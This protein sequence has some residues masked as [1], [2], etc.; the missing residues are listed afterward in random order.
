MEVSKSAGLYL[1]D[2]D[3]DVPLETSPIQGANEGKERFQSAYTPS[4]PPPSK[5]QDIYAYTD[6]EAATSANYEE[7]LSSA[8]R[9]EL[10]AQRSQDG[11]RYLTNSIERIARSQPLED[12]ADAAYDN[13]DEGA[14]DD[15]GGREPAT[16]GVTSST[17]EGGD[18]NE[19]FQQWM[20]SSDSLQKYILL[21]QHARDF[22]H[23]ASTFGTLADAYS[24]SLGM[25]LTHSTFCHHRGHQGRIIIFERDLPVHKKSIKPQTGLGY[26]WAHTPPLVLPLGELTSLFPLPCLVVRLWP[27]GRRREI[28]LPRVFIIIYYYS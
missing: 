21:S 19:R 27:A 13:L 14:S 4:L 11:T 24:N 23:A 6:S 2:A 16:S 5:E 28:P 12:E 9:M 22:V 20:A 10:G 25:T 18:S 7:V 26:V 15:E 1:Y 8:E 17:K 3:D